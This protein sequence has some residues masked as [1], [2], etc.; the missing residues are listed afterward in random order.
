MAVRRNTLFTIVSML[1]CF[2]ASVFAQEYLKVTQVVSI[3]ATADEPG[4]SNISKMYISP[5][6][7]K[8]DYGDGAVL[9]YKDAE[10]KFYVLFPDNK[11]FSRIDL[12]TVKPFIEQINSMMGDFEIT[13]GKTAREEK[14]AD[15]DTEVW[16]FLASGEKFEMDISVNI[17]TDYVSIPV[18]DKC[19]I[20]MMKYQGRRAA[21]TRELIKAMG[22]SLKEDIAV[23]MDGQ[24]M[25]KSVI[26]AEI[27][28]DIIEDS[29]FMIPA[30][31]KEVPI[32]EEV[33]KKIFM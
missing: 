29:E 15:S 26:T 9:L 16:N 32:T 1:L 10:S 17:S 27:D 23:T 24:L 31:Y 2:C 5:N 33:F 6:A 30:D 7:L 8:M 4:T 25:T 3:E 22:L 13:G 19:R 20:E 18:Y 21:I 14:V 11:E 28:D 12:E